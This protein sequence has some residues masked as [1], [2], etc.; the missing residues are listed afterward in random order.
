[1]P[2]PW[3]G[4][5]RLRLASI[6]LIAAIAAL[7]VMT[8]IAALP[9]LASELILPLRGKV[10]EYASQN[11]TGGAIPKVERGHMLGVACA[12]VDHSGVDVRVVMKD[13]MDEA[14]TGYGAVLATEQTISHG[15]VHVRVPDLPGLSD[16]TVDVKV[17]VT[18]SRGTHTCDVGRIR[19]V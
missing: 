19:I 17:Y 9:A 7:G 11:E 6:G 14:P 15:A 8:Q 18:D 10:T 2:E 4:R 13:V 3:E 16:H 12:D 1:M 5:V